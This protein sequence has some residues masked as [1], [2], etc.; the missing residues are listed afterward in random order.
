M[1]PTAFVSY[2]ENREAQEASFFFKNFR[3]LDEDD[4]GLQI[5]TDVFGRP[6]SDSPSD[7]PLAKMFNPDHVQ[8]IEV[9]VGAFAKKAAA[10][11]LAKFHERSEQRF[12]KAVTVI[13][14]IFKDHPEECEEVIGVV[15]RTLDEERAA[16][17]VSAV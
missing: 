17:I 9:T 15:R 16:T 10:P 5:P 8:N 6:V 13:E 4:A 1:L 11:P 2:S 14:R 3:H 7:D 12:Q